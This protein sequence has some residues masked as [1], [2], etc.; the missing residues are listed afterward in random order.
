MQVAAKTAIEIAKAQKMY[1]VLDADGLWLIQNEP[2][3]IKGYER[4]I[5]TPNVMEFK[6][7]A[8]KL[9]SRFLKACS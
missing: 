1:I 4:V 7:L 6:R 9:V 8:D 5:L 2:D 3:L